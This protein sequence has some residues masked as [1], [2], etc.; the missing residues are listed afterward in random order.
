MIFPILSKLNKDVWSDKKLSLSDKHIYNCVQ[1]LSGSGNGFR[2]KDL[3]RI[4]GCGFDF[5]AIMGSIKNLEKAG[6]LFVHEIKDSIGKLQHI[7]ISNNSNLGGID[8]KNVFT[9]NFLDNSTVFRNLVFNFLSSKLIMKRQEKAITTNFPIKKG[10]GDSPVLVEKNHLSTILCFRDIPI[11]TDYVSHLTKI[12]DNGISVKKIVEIIVKNLG[13]IRLPITDKKPVAAFLNFIENTSEHIKNG[14]CLF[15]ESCSFLSEKFANKSE[16]FFAFLDKA[17]VEKKRMYKPKQK[18][19]IKVKDNPNITAKYSA[20]IDFWNTKNLKKHKNY[21]TKL[22]ENAVKVMKKLEKGTFNDC[23]IRYNTDDFYEAIEIMDK[24]ANDPEVKPTG[25]KQKEFLKKMSIEDFFFSNYSGNSTFLRIMESGLQTTVNPYS[26]EVFNKL[27][28]YVKTVTKKDVSSKNKNYLAIF[29][30]SV[31]DFFL[32]HRKRIDM[33]CTIF[34]L[35]KSIIY[36]ITKSGKWLN[37]LFLIS[38]EMK[39]NVMMQVCLE[40]GYILGVMKQYDDVVYHAVP[41]TQPS[42]FKP[43][44]V[45]ESEA[46]KRRR[47]LMREIKKGKL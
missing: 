27:C 17:S 26:D 43:K 25:I 20:V 31:R 46:V 14:I 42:V 35:C 37:F 28:M 1:N 47:E 40:E 24:M 39:L 36:S 32:K 34:A 8:T 6:I 13:R 38:E 10:R 3:L 41:K 30:N 12:K 21:N 5:A 33:E 11:N 7:F 4:I 23:N 19:E 9:L 18:N 29:L 15:L 16:K 2:S 45:E 44:P 22:I